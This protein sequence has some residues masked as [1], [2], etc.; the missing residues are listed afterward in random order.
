M[1]RWWLSDSLVIILEGVYAKKGETEQTVGEG[2]ITCCAATGTLLC[3]LFPSNWLLWLAVFVMVS[4]LSNSFHL[5]EELRWLW[6]RLIPWSAGFPQSTNYKSRSHLTHIL[7]TWQ[8]VN[9]AK[10]TSSKL[11]NENIRSL[12]PVFKFKLFYTECLFRLS[13]LKPELL[14]FFNL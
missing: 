1:G 8:Y 12:T 7:I 13:G 14:F 2:A 4:P 3:S 9:S 10:K 5:S 11:Q 6:S